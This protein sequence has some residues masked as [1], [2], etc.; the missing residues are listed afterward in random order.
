MI[1]C[2]KPKIFVKDKTNIFTMCDDAESLLATYK[3]LV[4]E[5]GISAFINSQYRLRQSE[6]DY[7]HCILL[8]PCASK[9]ATIPS[10]RAQVSNKRKSISKKRKNNTLK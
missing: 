8:K 2:R 4:K 1:T 5:I 10:G 9:I 7:Q 3:N 6:L